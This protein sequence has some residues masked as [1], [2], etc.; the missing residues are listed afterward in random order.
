MAKDVRVAVRDDVGK[1]TSEGKLSWKKLSN[2][3]SSMFKSVPGVSGTG[4]V[5]VAKGVYDFTTMGGAAATTFNLLPNN[6]L[7]PANAIITKA[8]VHCLVTGVG[9]GSVSF[10]VNSTVDIKAALA[11]T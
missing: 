10:G 6:D 3:F 11:A 7:I 4:V 5:M 8:F 1:R 2:V 9:A